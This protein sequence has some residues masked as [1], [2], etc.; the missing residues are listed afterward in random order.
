M[1]GKSHAARAKPA[2]SSMRDRQ[3]QDGE[4]NFR[5][6]LRKCSPPPKKK[7]T[8]TLWPLSERNRTNKENKEASRTED[9]K[10]WKDPAKPTKAAREDCSGGG[11]GRGI[12]ISLISSAWLKESQLSW[13]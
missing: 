4:E 10:R 13:E 6:R 3:P 2:W 5:R 8:L 9:S 1:K 7:K 11:N 12:I